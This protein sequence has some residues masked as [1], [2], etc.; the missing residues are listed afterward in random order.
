[1]ASDLRTPIAEVQH[2]AR[3][4]LAFWFDALLPEQWFTKSDGLDQEIADLFGD[5]RDAVLADGAAS[6]D[7]DPET[8][9]AAVIL[10]DQ[11]SR[12][13]YRGQAEAFAGDALAQRMSRLAVERGWDASMPKEHRQFLYLPFEHAEDAELQALSL[14][15]FAALED[16]ELM[17]YARDH[18]EVFRRFGRFPGR[19]E[20]LGRISTPDELD[21]LSQPGAGW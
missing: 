1:M 9:L 14:R 3:Q 13:M 21:Y 4:V 5:L 6:W 2:R 10:L 19:N 17:A 20:A 15:C 8:L 12:N 7:D 18:A 11:F 16:E